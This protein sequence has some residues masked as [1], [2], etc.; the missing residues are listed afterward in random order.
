M[1][2]TPTPHPIAQTAAD[3]GRVGAARAGRDG[4][5]RRSTGGWPSARPTQTPA[6]TAGGGMEQVPPVIRRRGG[7]PIGKADDGAGFGVP[8]VA[9]RR[10]GGAKARVTLPSGVVLSVPVD[11]LVL[12]RAGEGQTV[13]PPAQGEA[14]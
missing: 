1:T 10:L 2:T 12:D 4:T 6:T 7:A 8:G 13:T 9:G 14:S 5:R 11:Q 3:G